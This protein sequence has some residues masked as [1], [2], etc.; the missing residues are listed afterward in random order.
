MT[1]SHEERRRLLSQNMQ[2][3]DLV[4][5]V[6]TSPASI[7]YLTGLTPSSPP[8]LVL[9]SDPAVPPV[10]VVRGI[11]TKDLQQVAAIPVRGA[12]FGSPGVDLIADA[13]RAVAR[14]GR[15][16][17]GFDEDATLS[18]KLL[19]MQGTMPWA[20]LVP[21]AGL[22]MALRYVKT[23]EEIALMGRAAEVSDEA[24][25][26]A[27]EAIRS[28]KTEAE[29]AAAAETTWR[30]HGLG[31]AYDVLIGSGKRSAALRRFPSLIVPGRDDLVRFDFAARLSPASGFGYNNDLTRTFTSGKP[32]PANEELLKVGLAVFQATVNALR[33]GRSIG[34]AADQGLR[35]VN[36]TRYE[37]WTHIVGHGIGAD[38]HE[39]PAFAQGS[40]FVMQAGNCFAI[41]P[42]VCIP[43]ER[44]V[45]FENTVVITET[46][47]ESL[48][49]LDLQ[50]WGT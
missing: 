29:A 2:Q 31:P 32:G 5:V 39:P 16:R 19:A 20:E 7:Y 22:I 40:T 48:N 43:G 18:T 23:P 37:E 12:P 15:R 13:V 11:E 6:I 35:E 41:E 42:M 9:P 25:F 27:V 30:S 36:G 49:K 34:E 33:P 24:M 8:G 50:L 14:N 21:S 10:L 4:A 38:V 46:G 3:A 47:W 28:G 45:C 26:V 17:I 44:A 1:S